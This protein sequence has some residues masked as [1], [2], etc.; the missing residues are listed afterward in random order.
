MAD[1]I[2]FDKLDASRMAWRGDAAD[3]GVWRAPREPKR[4]DRR[5]ALR[6]R[7]TIG[8]GW[9]GWSEDPE[10]IK[11]PAW[12]LD[13]SVEGC[14]LA[15]EGAPRAGEPAYLR[16]DGPSLLHWFPVR[17][18]DVL[19]GDGSVGAVRVLFAE[20]CPYVLCMGLVHGRFPKQ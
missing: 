9:I 8:R 3:P 12:I 2:E 6:Y 5:S 15:A 14:L 20:G 17:V 10:F 13:V 4:R 7:A 19:Q 16:L 18:L 1:R 11:R